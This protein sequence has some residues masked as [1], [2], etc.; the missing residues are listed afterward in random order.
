[1]PVRVTALKRSNTSEFQVQL[2]GYIDLEFS[3]LLHHPVTG[4]T[5]AFNSTLEFIHILE[6]FFDNA[7]FPQSTSKIR[8]FGKKASQITEEWNE[9]EQNA[10]Q[11]EATP[12]EKPTFIVRVQY[13]QNATWQ[14]T[15]QWVEQK[16]TQQFRSVLEMIKLMEKAVDVSC[17]GDEPNKM[18]GW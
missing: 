13:R 5:W 9:L 15:I 4:Y 2:R 3:G 12:I 6:C 7:N 17:E 1:M 11:P 18:P 10:L 8:G 14:G 16:K